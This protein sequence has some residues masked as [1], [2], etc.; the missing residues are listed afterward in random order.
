MGLTP[1]ILENIYNLPGNEWI[2]IK[3]DNLNA[4]Y[5]YNIVNERNDFSM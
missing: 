2:F 3:S 1:N 4:E 5:G